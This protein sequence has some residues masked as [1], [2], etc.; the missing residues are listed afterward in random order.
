MLEI[1]KKSRGVYFDKLSTSTSI[2]S[3]RMLRQA[4]H[5]CSIEHAIYVL[6][7]CDWNEKTLKPLYKVT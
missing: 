5:T 1:N 3:A 7:S 6:V 2:S 4:H